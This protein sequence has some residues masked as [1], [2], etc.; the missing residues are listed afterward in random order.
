MK[1]WE[2]A[3]YL[4]SPILIFCIVVIALSFATSLSQ[5]QTARKIAQNAFPSVVLLVME[6]TNGQPVS[7]GSGFFVKDDIVVTNLHV[8]ESAARGYA[9]IVGQK[10]KYEIKG[11]VGIDTQR[12]LGLLKIAGVKA[13]F[14][15]LGDINQVAVGDEVYAIGNPQ[16]LEGTFSQGIVSSI[17]QIG[18]DILFQ[19]TAPISPGSSGGPVLNALGK[20]IG[21]A[22][23]TFS[24]GQ[25]LNFAIPASYL[26][27]L[28]SEMKPVVPLSAK[29]TAKERKSIL[30]DLGGRNIEGVIGGQ[31]TWGSYT[32]PVGYYTYSFSL[33]NQLK[34]PIKDVYCLVIFYDRSDNPIDIDVVRYSQV[35]PAGLA[36]RVE[37]K[38]YGS[39]QEL[40]A[41]KYSSTPSTKIEFRILDFKIIE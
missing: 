37:S 27:V 7:L 3:L 11:I 30:D 19:I 18:S 12:D 2:I 38:V 1:K 25:N 5:A 28:L 21:I 4:N 8:I 17:R 9:K 31:L 26:G 14:L 40:T 20:V 34:Q 10:P 39:V 29:A 32:V 23:A 22:V 6:D 13:P 24:G 33:R 41:G 15:T 36:R 16:G 35:I